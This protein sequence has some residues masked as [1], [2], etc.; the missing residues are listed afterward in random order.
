MG[1]RV[2]VELERRF[3]SA[4]PELQAAKLA[5]LVGRGAGRAAMEQFWT[6]F[7]AML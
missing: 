3:L 6:V 4:V 2:L 7:D 1:S 5:D